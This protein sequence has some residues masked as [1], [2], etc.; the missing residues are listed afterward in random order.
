MNSNPKNI[1][2]YIRVSTKK[3]DG[4]CSKENQLESI[5]A[6]INSKGWDKVP[7]KIYDDTY[8]AS[9]GI[10][11]SIST[12]LFDNATP[13]VFIRE[14]IRNLFYDASFKMFDKLIVYSHD[15]LSRDAHESLLINHTL[16]KLNIEIIYSKAGEQ[17]DSEND[18]MNTFLE[19]LLSNLSALESSIIG[20]RTFIGNRG[21]ITNNLWA[22]GPP[23]YGY[24][25]EPIKSNRKKSKLVINYTEARIVREIFE[26]YIMGYSPNNIA[27][28][29]KSKYKFNKDRLW[30]INSIKSIL[31]NP[32][33]TGIMTWNK[34]GGRKNPRKKDSND[35]VY[36][37]PDPNIKLIDKDIWN[38]AQELKKLQSNNPKFLSTDFL[39]KGLLICGE[40][41]ELFQTK[42]HGNSSGNVY[43]CRHNNLT[44]DIPTLTIKASFIHNAVINELSSITSSLLNEPSNVNSL[45][46]NYS[47]KFKA[48]KEELQHEKLQ[49]LTD[50]SNIEL[51]LVKASNELNIL[52]TTPLVSSD[53]D[54]ELYNKSLC[55]IVSI[56]EFITLLTLEKNQLNHKL[57]SINDELLYNIIPENNFKDYIINSISPINNI[58]KET[59]N[60]VKNRCLRVLLI[61]LIDSIKVSSSLSIEI[62]FK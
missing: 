54:N 24:N 40:C 32:V 36:S 39:F 55:L 15:R 9:L 4:N 56:E 12:S 29:I 19:N 20:G 38:K 57:S 47:A 26:L 58:L 62:L 34:K 45:Y 3:Q 52:N 22:G 30:T 14:G 35:Y 10:K 41:G 2:I 60:K 27:E 53:D 5:F 46:I 37:K 50:I 25:L 7:Y 16:K 48:K 42:N 6:L 28:L 51:M 13:S 49:I 44:E 17:I 1:A 8:S 31:S 61:N 11:D 43:Y 18:S 59:N 23:P 21:N 33:Y